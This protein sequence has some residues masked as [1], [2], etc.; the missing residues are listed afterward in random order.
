MGIEPMTY[1]VTSNYSTTELTNLN[2]YKT[3]CNLF[4]S[5]CQLIFLVGMAGFE[6]TTSCTQ[7][8]NST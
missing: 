3:K 7:N 8:K 4:N 2:F 6:P 5:L 1:C